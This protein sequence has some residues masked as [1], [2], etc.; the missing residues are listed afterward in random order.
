VR[1]EVLTAAG[2]IDEALAEIEAATMAARAPF[3]VRRVTDRPMGRFL[4]RDPRL[5]PILHRIRDRQAAVRARVPATLKASGIDPGE[6]A[7]P[8]HFTADPGP[9][10][11]NQ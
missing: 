4:A 10:T 5:E 2:R 3:E 9:A 7:A 1:A 6:L 11:Q 8:P